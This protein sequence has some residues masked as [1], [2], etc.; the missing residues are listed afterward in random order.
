MAL[1]RRDPMAELYAI[2]ARQVVQRVR[3][4]NPLDSD[5]T[6]IPPEYPYLNRPKANATISS[7]RCARTFTLFSAL[8]LSPAS[9]SHCRPQ[10]LQCVKTSGHKA[11]CDYEYP[12][13]GASK[14]QRTIRAR[15]T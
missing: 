8:T 11:G 7:H 15:R 3:P 1:R 14:W 13:N 2:Q 5:I 9:V 12:T 4:A 10:V 6:L